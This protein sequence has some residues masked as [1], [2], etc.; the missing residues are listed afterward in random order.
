[1]NFFEG[2][3]SVGQANM[4]SGQVNTQ[5]KHFTQFNAHGGPNQSVNNDLS[6]FQMVG[7]GDHTRINETQFMGAGRHQNAFDFNA[8]ELHTGPGVVQDP[9]QKFE[10]LPLEPTSQVKQ[11]P[12]SAGFF[13][14]PAP[15]QVSAGIK[16]SKDKIKFIKN[17]Q[18]GGLELKKNLMAQTGT[19]TAS[20]LT[21]PSK[22]SGPP[23]MDDLPM[24]QSQNNFKF[25]LNE[26]SDQEKTQVLSLKQGPGLTQVAQPQTAKASRGASL[27]FG[28]GQTKFDSNQTSAT[29]AQSS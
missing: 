22:G 15:A 18:G 1:M 28:N 19:F 23:M 5:T 20:N 2:F 10:E 4:N 16:L 24:R 7:T 25:S 6:S 17:N 3:T 27:L 11:T 12:M 29:A 13:Q 26:V 14:P 9:V 8:P 21:S